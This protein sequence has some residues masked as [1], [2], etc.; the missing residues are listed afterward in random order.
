MPRRRIGD[1]EAVLVSFRVP[2]ELWRR[3]VK[4]ADAE[5]PVRELLR[6]AVR[7]FVERYGGKK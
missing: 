5:N 7:M 4:L 1:E 2:G 6:E 3:F